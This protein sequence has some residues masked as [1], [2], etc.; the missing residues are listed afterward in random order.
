MKK[1]FTLIAMAAMA[2][3][4]NAQ[5]EWRPSEEAPAAGSSIIKG[6]L[7]KVSTVFETTCGKIMDEGG[8]P[9]PVT[10][11]GKTFQTYMQIRVDAA[12]TAD[13]PTGTDKGGSTPLVITAK[14]NVDLT[15]Y[16]RRQAANDAYAENDGKDM[17]LIDQ[18]KPS[19]AIAAATYESFDIDGSYANA[20]KVFKLEEGKVY[21]LWA[22]GTTGRLYGLDYA[23]G[24]G[25]GGGGGEAGDGT[26]MISFDGMSAANKLEF[27][28]GFTLQITG[29]ETKTI[30]NG[31]NL[32]INGTDYQ[33]MKVSNGAQ[34]TLTLPAGKVAKDITFYS[35]VNKDAAT[36]RDSYWKEV[37]G[38]NYDAT[39]SGG[40]F[41]CFN[42]DL[43]NPD[44]RTYDFGENR[45]NAITFTNTGEQCCYVIEI[46]IAAGEVVSGIENVKAAVVDL[47]AP[48][49]NLA[50]QKVSENYKGV[51]IKNGQKMI[52]K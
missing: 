30:G 32:N 12:P 43:S 24:T 16:Y 47:N 18:S 14:K 46:T 42:T 13:N 2:L 9:A 20:I 21:T 22:R 8:E 41:Q 51:V 26:F 29:N 37:A 40:L 10:F 7:L 28:N 44:K 15:V 34:N 38:V 11:G 17:K 4:V 35:Y 3:G 25:A 33:S 6:D 52:Q 48:A 39:T 19:A 23:E 45:L 49:Y 1:I 50:G 36:D 31:K 27:S 5:T